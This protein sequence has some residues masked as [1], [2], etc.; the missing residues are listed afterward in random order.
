MRCAVK[1]RRSVC[2]LHWNLGFTLYFLISDSTPSTLRE[3]RVS[4]LVDAYIGNNQDRFL[5]ELKSLLRIPSVSTL[6]EHRS[7]IER[8]CQ[9]VSEKLQAAGMKNVRSIKTSGHPM[10][11][12]EW[13]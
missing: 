10:I 12:G 4:S 1:A 8:A 2:R 7:D 13:M 9:F 5:D 11:Y 3:I 6:P